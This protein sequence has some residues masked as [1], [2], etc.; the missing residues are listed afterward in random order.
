M[1]RSLKTSPKDRTER[2][3]SLVKKHALCIKSMAFAMLY[4][5]SSA[6]QYI[7]GMH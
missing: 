7:A 6:V 3:F 4:A 5:L 1:A 2:D